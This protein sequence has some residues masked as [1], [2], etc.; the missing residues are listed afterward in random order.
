MIR[1]YLSGSTMDNLLFDAA[2][3][4]PLSGPDKPD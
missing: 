4:I 2:N 3:V 1:E